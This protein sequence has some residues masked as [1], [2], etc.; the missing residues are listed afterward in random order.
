MRYFH[1]KT[2][3]FCFF[4]LCLSKL[5]VHGQSSGGVQNTSSKNS[6]TLRLS[7]EQAT[8]YALTHNYSVINARLEVEIAK[9]KILETTTIGLPQVNGEI[10][11]QNMLNIPTQVLPAKAFNPMAEYGELVAVQFGTNYTAAVGLTATQLI[12]DGAYIVGL[13]ASKTYGKLSKNQLG[14]TQNDLKANVAQAY[15]SALVA[16]E[17]IRIL[18]QSIENSKKLLSETNEVYKSGFIE[19]NDVDQLNLLVQNLQN[20]LKRSERQAD[21]ALQLLKFQIGLDID[22]QIELTENLDEILLSL[23]I[24]NLYNTD[25]QSSKHIDYQLM[26]NQQ[27]LMQ[28]NL[29]KEKYAYLPSIG[30]FLSHQENALRNEFTFFENGP[31]Y[32]TTVWGVSIKVP[33]FDSGMKYAKIKQAK[34]E[35]EKTIISTTQ[36]EQSLKLQAQT[37]K[38]DLI[39]SYERLLTEKQNLLLAEKIQNKTLIKYQEGLASSLDLNQVQ[40]QLLST[41]GNYINTVFDLLNAKSRFDKAMNFNQSTN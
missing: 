36:V 4:L 13:Q 10:N 14:K 35:Y 24:E 28:L 16:K 25:F 1:A 2:F 8:N 27:N 29:K 33:I 6:E 41:Q 40:N 34:M 17:N 3:F 37:S 9:K 39:S 26:L 30:A 11:F 18:G 12:F 32:P 19:E 20:S 31:W 22:N 38:A 5:A 21:L 7:L 15:Y 23:N